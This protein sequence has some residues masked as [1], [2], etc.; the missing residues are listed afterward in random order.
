VGATEAKIRASLGE[1]EEKKGSEE[2][3]TREGETRILAED[4]KKDSQIK[5]DQQAPRR[6]K[7]LNRRG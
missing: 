3:G 2:K 1:G 6:R 5:G 4:Q 7:N